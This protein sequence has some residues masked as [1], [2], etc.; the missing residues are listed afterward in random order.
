MFATSLEPVDRQSAA[1]VALDPGSFGRFYDEALPRILGYFLQRTGG[2]HAVAEDLTQE[3][4]VAAV[5]ELRRGRRPNEPMPWIFGIARHKLLDHYRRSERS[6][7]LQRSI[8]REQEELAVDAAPGVIRERVLTALQAVPAAQRVVLVLHYLDG[9]SMREAAHLLGKS[10]KAVE[11]LL[12]RGRESL[13]R[14]YLEA[15]A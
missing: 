3:T 9:L 15:P 2:S 13:K 8:E 7:R 6:K 5:R 4:F 12:G 14:A 11:S 10:E 1:G